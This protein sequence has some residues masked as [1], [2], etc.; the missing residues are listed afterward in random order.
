[1]KFEKNQVESVEK[2]GIF[3]GEEVYHVKSKGGFS[4]MC[5]KKA[6][7][8]L[9]PIGTGSHR[10]IAKHMADMKVGGIDWDQEALYKM[11]MPNP[12]DSTPENHAALADHHAKLYNKYRKMAMNPTAHAEEHNSYYRSFRPDHKDM[13]P[14]NVH[15]DMNMHALWNQDVALKHYQM[16]G[17]TRPQAVERMNQQDDP[18]Y[19]L[20]T[21]A[22]HNDDYLHRA[23]NLKNRGKSAPHGLGY[24]FTK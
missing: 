11:E 15:H 6:S 4:M 21:A 13:H 23:W 14:A 16:A 9:E 10:A 1:M 20:T 3:K 12:D 8:R 2:V 22:P 19:P 17:L 18:S 24:D 7:G 5:L